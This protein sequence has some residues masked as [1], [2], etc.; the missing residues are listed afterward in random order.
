MYGVSCEG[1]TNG[2]ECVQDGLDA[3]GNVERVAWV[4]DTRNVLSDLCIHLH[5][6]LFLWHDPAR[7]GDWIRLI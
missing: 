2:D 1:G 3:D 7:V 5:L 4:P 6:A